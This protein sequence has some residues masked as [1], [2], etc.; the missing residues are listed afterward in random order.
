MRK[1]R[2][3]HFG[4]DVGFYLR[5]IRGQVEAWG[6]VDAVGVEQRHGGHLEVLAHA[7]QFLGQGRAFEE[8]EGGAGVEFDVRHRGQGLGIRG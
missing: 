2:A 8:A 5:F 7:D 3:C 1:G 4:A 6:A